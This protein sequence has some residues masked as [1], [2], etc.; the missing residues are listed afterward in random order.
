MTQYIKLTAKVKLVTNWLAR[1]RC[2][3]RVPTSL[4]FQPLLPPSPTKRNDI[5]FLRR[6]DKRFESTRERTQTP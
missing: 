5:E 3:V 4:P 1:W 2:G 6:L